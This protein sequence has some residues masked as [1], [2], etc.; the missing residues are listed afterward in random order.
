M[1]TIYN[2][3]LEAS[4]TG[5]LWVTKCTGM[6]L[7][8]SNLQTKCSQVEKSLH[9]F[10]FFFFWMNVKFIQTKKKTFYNECILKLN[11]VF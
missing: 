4:F 7:I 10:F 11:V 6:E 3:I 5:I 2:D 1:M 8:N 9:D